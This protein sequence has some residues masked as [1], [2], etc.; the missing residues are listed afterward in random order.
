MTSTARKFL[1]CSH[2]A[3]LG[4]GVLFGLRGSQIGIMPILSDTESAP[5]HS[6]LAKQGD[7]GEL[8][9]T[10]AAPLTTADYAAA[11]D[12]LKGR[13]LPRQ[14]RVMIEKTLLE[15]WSVK[16]LT[17]TVHAV[18]GEN[19]DLLGNSALPGS[20]QILLKHGNWSAPEPLAWKPGA[21]AGNGS[22]A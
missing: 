22:N 14:E 7:G 6:T 2:L 10:S 12:S 1:W 13:F 20:L 8:S 19:P 9:S 11:W 5:T 16:D 18:F 21:S 4:L 3:V 15:E 17:A